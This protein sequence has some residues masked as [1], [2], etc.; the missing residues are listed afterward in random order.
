MSIIAL[1]MGFN[2][3]IDDGDDNEDKLLLLLTAIDDPSY[4]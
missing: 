3:C 2:K 1:S 4:C